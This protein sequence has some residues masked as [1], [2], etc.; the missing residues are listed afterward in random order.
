MPPPNSTPG[1]ETMRAMDNMSLEGVD[2]YVRV[3]VF[4]LAIGGWHVEII[5]YALALSVL[6][7]SHA[8]PALS[9]YLLLLLWRSIQ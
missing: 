4:S 8:L 2:P 1:T 9:K 6:R 7:E 3:S 5:S